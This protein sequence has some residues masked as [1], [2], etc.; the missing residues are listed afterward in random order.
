MSNLINYPNRKNSVSNNRKTSYANRGK[1]LEEDLNITNEFYRIR[2]KALVHK[3]PTPIQIV[4]VDFG[5][6]SATK[7]NEAYFK[8]PS[9]TDYNGV[10]N[11][12]HLDFDAK[13]CSSKTSFPM[14]SVHKHQISHLKDVIKHGGIAFIIIRVQ[15]IDS[16]Y[17][18]LAQ[19]IF[20]YLEVN[21]RKSI[22]IPWIEEN[23]FKLRRSLNPRVDYLNAV[24]III[25]ERHNG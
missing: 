15:V 6:R 8:E 13:E 21:N 17:L 25:K 2:G 12:Y 3:K 16:D 23:G 18:L 4:K 20:D 9:T 7:I 10:Y 5:L 24:D 11:G 22:A 19:D 1:T 14:K